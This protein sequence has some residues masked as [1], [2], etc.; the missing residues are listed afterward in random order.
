MIV[1]LLI[2]SFIAGCVGTALGCLIAVMIKN[3]NKDNFIY[4]FTAGF[5]IVIVMFDLIPSSITYSSYLL[6]FISLVVGA[7]FVFILNKV[8]HGGIDDEKKTMGLLLFIAITLHNFPEGVAIGAGFEVELSFAIFVAVI[9]SL[10]NIPEGMAMGISLFQAGK[11]KTQV[12]LFGIIAGLP[13]CLG[14]LAGNFFAKINQQFIGIG[15]GFASGAMLYVCLAELVPHG[16]KKNRR[17]FY[18]Y[19]AIGVIIGQIVLILFKNLI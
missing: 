1:N 12:I 2:F 10:H 18:F 5:L 6:C 15:L 13:T 14:A 11:T 9:M 17:K 16:R 19:L 8:L 7:A 4:G 3:N